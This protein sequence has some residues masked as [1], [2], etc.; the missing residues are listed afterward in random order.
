MSMNP[1]DANTHDAKSLHA[2]PSDTTVHRADSANVDSAIDDEPDTYPPAE[3][4]YTVESDRPDDGVLYTE[5][6]HPTDRVTTTEITSEFAAPSVDFSQPVTVPFVY[7]DPTPTQSTSV[8]QPSASPQNQQRNGRSRTG[9]FLVGSAVAGIIGAILTVGL[10]SATGAFDDPPIVTQ[11]TTPVNAEQAVQ[12]VEVVAPQIINGIGSS[13]NATAVALK[14]VPSVVTIN[15][16]DQPEDTSLPPEGIGSGSGVVIS[17]DGY[18]ITNHHVIEN[19]DT[20]FVLF[21]DGREYEAT[22]VGSDELTD[23]AVLKISADALIPV[24]FGSTDNMRVGDPT[25]AIGNP[26]GQD[27]GASVSVGI[28]SAFNRRVDFGNDDFLHGMLQTD[29]AINSGSSGGGLFDAEGKLIGITSAIGVSQAG[30][31]GI[32]YA[33]PIELVDRISKEII[34]TGDVEHPFLGV[35]IGTY[36]ATADDDARVPAG[37]NIVS[38]EGTDSAAALAGLR[39]DDI[40]IGIG[41]KEIVDQTGLILAVRLYRVG[42]EVDF[43][44]DRDGDELTITVVM[45]RRPANLQG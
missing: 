5:A 10:L 44:V 3:Q 42:D 13:L 2:S 24:E 17:S 27:G 18:L 40:V 14:A 4:V 9:L 6:E 35:Q 33:I 20:Y 11:D 41:G 37:A 7:D 45:G 31:E 22:L 8:N 28:I 38:I 26:L 34:E 1:N 36:I 15:V 32:G 21:Q 29:A 19:A 25:V 30:P 12:P 39:V 43:T 16:Y 23:L